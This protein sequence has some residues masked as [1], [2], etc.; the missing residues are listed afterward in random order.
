MSDISPERRALYEELNALV[1]KFVEL[2]NRDA[3]NGIRMMATAH[4]LLIGSEE[5]DPETGDSGGHTSVLPANGCQASWKT[6]GIVNM[7]KA[8]LEVD[9]FCGAA[10][11]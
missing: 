3:T 2:D 9:H 11:E 4:V 5:F 7:A 10:G 6:S 1:E 8:L